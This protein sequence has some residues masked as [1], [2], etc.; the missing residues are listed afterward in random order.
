M[1]ITFLSDFVLDVAQAADPI[2]HKFSVQKLRN[3]QDTANDMDMITSFADMVQSESSLPANAKEETRSI[4]AYQKFE[5]FMLQT[6]IQNMFTIDTP[7]VFGKGLG[8][9][10]W[11]SMLVETISREMV[12]SGGI[13][14]ANMLEN[15][16][17]LLEFSRSSIDRQT[18][19][20]TVI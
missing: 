19:A 5:A 6:M 15:R 3:M 20:K 1:A 18:K 4:Q 17:K 16:Q 9:E 13:G 10:F 7:S 14:V 8:G 2:Q 11:K 12:A